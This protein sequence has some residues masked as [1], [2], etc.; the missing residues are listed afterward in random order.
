MT[1]LTSA[2]LRERIIRSL[3]ETRAKIARER[4]AERLAPV[5]RIALTCLIFVSGMAAGALTVALL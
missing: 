1:D 3:N 2:E 4:R 5:R